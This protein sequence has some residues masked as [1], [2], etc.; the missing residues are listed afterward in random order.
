[1]SDPP[2]LSEDEIRDRFRR[3]QKNKRIKRGGTHLISNL[4]GGM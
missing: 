1:M 2:L 4:T 3:G